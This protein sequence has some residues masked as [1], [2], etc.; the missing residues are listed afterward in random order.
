MVDEL[1]P[2]SAPMRVALVYDMDAC[3]GPTGVTRHAL[4]QLERLAKRPE[5]ALTVVS[6]RISEPDGLVYWESLG[7]LSRR[8]LPVRTRDAL[9]WWRLASW[10]PVELWSHEVDWVYCPS[11]YAVPTRKARR[12]VT[13]HDVLQNLR[14]HPKF[15]PRLAQTFGQADL[16]LSVS[17]FNTEQLLEAFPE[18]Q[19]RVEYVPNGAEDLFFEPATESERAAVRVDLELPRGVPYLI[20]VAN[21]QPRKNL[22]RL[23]RAA[24]RLPEVVRGD[25]ALVLLGT[26]SDSE[27]RL[28]REAIT[29]LGPRALVRM[30]GYRQGKMLRAAYAEATALVFPSL[31]ESFGIPAVEA[32][33]QGIPVALADSTALPEIGG[34]AAWYFDPE[35][36]ESLLAALRDLLDQ[37][38][39]RTR[40][41]LLGREIAESYRWQAANDLLVHALA[42]RRGSH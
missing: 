33:A 15:R 22:V 8:E 37:S 20:S 34:A 32:M 5:V 19:G 11:E 6:G 23:V 2:G 24:G 16:I 27:A 38:D 1:E 17:R 4:A 35:N 9:R 14:S 3:R 40:R 13:C 41:A 7:D 42:S 29:A 36:E 21:F 28:V 12:A 25:L 10:P 39:E 26:G 31:C 18:C 30:P